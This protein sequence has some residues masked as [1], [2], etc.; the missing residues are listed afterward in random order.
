MF[1][2]FFLL[3]PARP[4][5]ACRKLGTAFWL[6]CACVLTWPLEAASRQPVAGNKGLVASTSPEASE[7]GASILK[8]GG[9]AADAAAAVGLALA[10]TWPAAGNLGGGGFSLVRPTKGEPQFIDYRETA[11]AAAGEKF[12][13]DEKGNLIPEA[14]AV[15]YRAPGV[16]GT[17]AGLELLHKRWG[18]LP[19][20][21]V[22]EPARRL[23]A[24]GFR[25][26]ESHI[27]MLKANEELLRRFP[28]TVRIFLPGGKLPAVGDLF[29]Q[30]DLA[31][32]L[33]V[34]QK[35]GAAGF[36]R[37]SLAKALVQDI[38]KNGGVI[39]A[40]DLEAYKV[41][42]REPL[43]GRFKEFELLTAPP[44]SSGGIVLLEM[45]GMIEKDDLKSMGAGS[46]AS[47]H[48]MIEAMRRA[49]ADRSEWL[50]DPAFVQNPITQLLDAS[51]LRQRRQEID[52]KRAT[53]S[54][55]IKAASLKVE[56]KEKPETTHFT[57]SDSSGMIVS[58]TYTLNG[59]FGSGA[60]AKG[61]GILLNNEMDDF[62]A[63][64]GEPNMYGLIQSARNSIAPGKRPLSS[65]TP[66][67]FLKNG[68]AVLALGS[69]GGPTI[70][71]TVF[72]VSLNVLVHGMNV[73]EAVDA[74][75]VH[76][77]WL[78]D[79]IVYEPEGLNPDSRQKLEAMG[80]R[81]TAKP[82]FMGDAQALYFDAEK[83]TWTGASDS[84]W[85]GEVAAVR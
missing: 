10:V 47:L 21:K 81:F 59:S 57:V 70:I 41:E 39:K 46:A 29:V 32:S 25:L 43:L 31:R 72:Q 84:R 2:A 6:S 58:S 50:G 37:G 24:D 61:T 75:R 14:S 7:I 27:R 71:N 83:G 60:T 8:Q 44:P 73:Q 23:A 53:A 76:Q 3:T 9:T 13:Q 28:E 79:E 56:D 12:Y 64:V 40:S 19:W 74:P 66:T 80:H 68:Q 35:E 20:S 22:V 17:V 16:P 52:L 77:Q 78:P 55:A 65:M 42:L 1:F 36:Y 18:K 34:I 26:R 4:S 62:A 11:P 82:R 51:Y 15:G 33:A 85:G 63:K 38:Q 69:P 48:L 49:F 30:K 45:L 54:A 67:I 5:L